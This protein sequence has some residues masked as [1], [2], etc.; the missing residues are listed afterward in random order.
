MIKT[1]DF[2]KNFHFI[3]C[4]CCKIL[5]QY[6]VEDIVRDEDG[7]NDYLPCPVCD[8]AIFDVREARQPI[9]FIEKEDWQK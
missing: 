7:Y 9:N 2:G 8:E 1:F 4:P 6:E 5:L 3:Q